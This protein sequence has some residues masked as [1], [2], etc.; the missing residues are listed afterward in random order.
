MSLQKE[1]ESYLMHHGVKG[2]R[3]GVRKEQRAVSKSRR[4]ALKRVKT[5]STKE[6]DDRISRLEKEK[7][8]RELTESEVSRG[9]SFVK[10]LLV[11]SGRQIAKDALVGIGKY[12]LSSIGKGF[13]T[14]KV[15]GTPY[16]T[17]IPSSKGFTETWKTPVR[18]RRTYSVKRAISAFEVGEM[19]ERAFGGGKKNK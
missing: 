2:Q 8:L 17:L 13:T 6:L 14:S 11:E 4:K 12:A 1:Y 18:E 7:R 19:F 9:R 15:Y 10:N 16:K 3:W 5:M